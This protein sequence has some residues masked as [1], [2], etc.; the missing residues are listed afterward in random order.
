MQIVTFE[1]A[2]RPTFQA[3]LPTVSQQPLGASASTIFKYTSITVV[4]VG[5]L[6]LIGAV[7]YASGYER[8]AAKVREG[9]FRRKR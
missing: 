5:A 2:R 7:V 3:S 1:G 6:A 4:T 8:C 9:H